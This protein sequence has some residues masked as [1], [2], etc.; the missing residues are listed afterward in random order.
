MKAV[1]RESGK[2][3]RSDFSCNFVPQ[4]GDLVIIN[5]YQYKVVGRKLNLDDNEVV[6]NLME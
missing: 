4:V 1:Y 2:T 3:L 6:V 5:T